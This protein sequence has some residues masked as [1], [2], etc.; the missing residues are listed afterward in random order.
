MKKIFYFIIISLLVGCSNT[1]F[2]QKNKWKNIYFNDEIASKKLYEVYHKFLKNSNF[3]YPSYD[4]KIVKYF[5]DI[6]WLANQNKTYSVEFANQLTTKEII[7]LRQIN[8]YKIYKVFYNN[9]KPKEAISLHTKLFFDD[10]GRTI[11]EIHGS[12]WDNIRF[13]YYGDIYVNVIDCRK[14]EK[15]TL[16]S[17]TYPEY[18]NSMNEL[19]ILNRKQ[20]VK[21]V[22]KHIYKNNNGKSIFKDKYNRIIKIINYKE[23]VVERYVY[24]NQSVDKIVCSYV[25]KKCIISTKDNKT[26]IMKVQKLNKLIKF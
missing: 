8:S 10:E 25:D 21:E 19:Y 2:Q 4:K 1:E 9:G 23:K 15:C 16:S 18:L 5:Q 6:R 26:S 14:K 7:A 3:F 13:N 17:Y 22:F 11:V 12:D 20:D 24:N